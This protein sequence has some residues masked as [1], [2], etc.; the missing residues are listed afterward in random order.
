MNAPTAACLGAL[1]YAA[2]MICLPVR[3]EP[4]GC[5]IA[6]GIT[7]SAAAGVGVLVLIY[8]LTGNL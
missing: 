6:L 8:W 7:L 5:H 2:V 4:V 1:V 3:S